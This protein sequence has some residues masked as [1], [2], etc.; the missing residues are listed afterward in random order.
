MCMEEV[1][2]SISSWIK[3]SGSQERHEKE[4]EK[5]ITQRDLIK[6]FLWLYTRKSFMNHEMIFLNKSP[7]YSCRRISRSTWVKQRSNGWKNDCKMQ[8][9]TEIKR[10][11]RKKRRVINTSACEISLLLYLTFQL[12]ADASGM[13][14][15]SSLSFPWFLTPALLLLTFLVVCFEY[16]LQQT[17]GWREDSC[18]LNHKENDN[19]TNSKLFNCEKKTRMNDK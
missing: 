17:L 10:K 14:F 19:N 18:S 11:R 8:H 15:R 1:S 9:K 4:Q 3:S 6:V 12:N 5:L 7:I 13:F 2:N 16:A